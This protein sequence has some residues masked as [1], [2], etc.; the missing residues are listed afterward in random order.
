VRNTF[1]FATFVCV[2][3][4]LLLAIAA[5]RLRPRQNY[6][7]EIDQKQNI[8]LA[9][10]FIQGE[11]K[12][13]SST[14]ES[15][16]SEKVQEFVIDTQGNIVEGKTIADTEED[17]GLLPLYK[18]SETGSIAY[19]VEGMGLWSILQGYFALEKDGK[20]VAG[21]TFYEQ[22]ETAGLGAEIV[23]PWFKNNFK[24]KSI[25]NSQGKLVSVAVAKGKAADAAYMEL[26]NAVDGISGATMTGR[27]VTD[28]LKKGVDTYKPYLEKIWNQKTGIP[29]TKKARV[30]PV[31]ESGGEE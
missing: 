6:N 25:V 9:L 23:K 30:S 4:S 1:I 17:K 31:S 11:T 19:P 24:G 8:L 16:Y 5:T 18:N 10:G 14:I 29:E 2:V 20:T 15:M 28:L 27:G 12:Y 21:I 13:T 22:K 26:L 3:C 7:V